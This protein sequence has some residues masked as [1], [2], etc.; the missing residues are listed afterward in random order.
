MVRNQ[1]S[2]RLQRINDSCEMHGMQLEQAS[3]LRRQH[4]ELLN[5]KINDLSQLGLGNKDEII[6]TEHLF[7][8]AVLKYLQKVGAPL[9]KLEQSDNTTQLNPDFILARPMR[10]VT[11]QNAIEDSN[12]GEHGQVNWIETEMRYGASTVNGETSTGIAV[13]EIISK[14][15]YYVKHYGPGAVVFAYGCGS[16]LR[17]SLR[18]LRISVLDSH[19]LDLRKMRKKQKKWCANKKGVILP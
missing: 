6:D 19:P 12:F 9:E 4:M 11:R 8:R 2:G 1:R 3:C 10:L 14:V 5:P 16:K 15:K 7:A 13:D 18:A 17:E